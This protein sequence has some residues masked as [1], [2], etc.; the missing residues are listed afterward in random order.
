MQRTGIVV[1]IVLGTAVAVGGS[2][3][4]PGP[5]QRAG[6]SEYQRATRGTRV[7]E[8]Q[9]G[10]AIKVLVEQ[11][12]LGGREVEI[13]EITF[14]VG[15]GAGGN[16]HVH[17]TV[18]I[19]YVLSGELDHIVNGESHILTPGMVGMVRTGDRVVHRVVGDVPVRALVIWAPGGEVER[20]AGSLRE[21]P[22]RQ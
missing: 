22:I 7:L 19:F 13:G 9:N 5:A 4:A 15:S 14:P 17:G 21:R 20:I 11:S 18:E 10:F 1:G 6:Q 12:N 16:G 3:S 8:G 2:A